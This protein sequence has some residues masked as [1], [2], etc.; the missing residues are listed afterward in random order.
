M[1][2]P[3]PQ[4]TKELPCPLTPEERQQAGKDLADVID[5]INAVEN[6]LAG[7]KAHAK[8]QITELE[9]RKR[10]L[11]HMI[12]TGQQERPVSTVWEMDKEKKEATLIRLDT[13]EAV[14]T[15]PM[16]MDELQEAFGFDEPEQP[17]D[18]AEKAAED[19]ETAPA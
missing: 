18:D 6:E 16:T 4:E 13:G 9:D 11:K 10:E 2:R 19:T 7:H 1:S 17:S 3:F 8:S 14:R 15:R 12:Q 5:E